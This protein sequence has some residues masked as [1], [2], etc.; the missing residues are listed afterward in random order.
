MLIRVDLTLFPPTR[1]FLA[2]RA[3]L[4]TA[5][6]SR[7]ALQAGMKSGDIVRICR[8]VYATRPLPDRG[9]YL[10]S[11]GVVDAGYLALVRSVLLRLGPEVCAG[12]RTAAVL[13]GFDL[14]VEPTQVELAVP[15]GGDRK[16]SGVAAIQHAEL[17][18]VTLKVLDL[19]PVQV[20]SAVQTVLH[21]ALLLP[22]AEAVVVA[23]SAL[24]R[25]AVTRRQLVKAAAQLRGTPGAV[26]VRQVIA[27]S[28][29]K[30]ESVLESLLRV[31]LAQAGIAAPET[32]YDIRDGKVFVGRVDFCWPLLRLIV[33]CDGR[34]W[35][36]PDDART[37]DRR[38]DNAFECLS[39]RV[40]RF[41]WAEVV[42]QPEY[43]LTQVRTCL[44]GW[45]SAA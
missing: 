13:W 44:E 26:Q 5:G 34:R 8:G 30:S 40:L 37:G 14:A 38:R 1:Q 4:R 31:L 17:D 39:W 33:E 18:I 35:H 11:G 19:E 22:L 24:R 27:L 25:K 23:D 10:L 42:H 20:T 6:L 29:P 7:R 41:S 32:Q 36:D 2:T 15:V 9:A 12:G 43:V 21:C 45:R 16:L 3:Q 28:D